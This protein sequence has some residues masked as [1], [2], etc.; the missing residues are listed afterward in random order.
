IKNIFAP[1]LYRYLPVRPRLVDIP[2]YSCVIRLFSSGYCQPG[3]AQQQQQLRIVETKCPHPFVG[4]EPFHICIKN[5][6]WPQPEHSTL[7][8]CPDLLF[9]CTGRQHP[10]Q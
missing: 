7:T 10:W 5:D 4:R 1:V 3:N 8:S 9:G 6:V 2:A